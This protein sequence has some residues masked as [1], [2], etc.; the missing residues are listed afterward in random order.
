MDSLVMP[1]MGVQ[2]ISRYLAGLLVSLRF[3]GNAPATDTSFVFDNRGGATAIVSYTVKQKQEWPG[4]TIPALSR[5]AQGEGRW[6]ELKPGDYLA[7]SDG[8]TRTIEVKTGESLR[9]AIVQR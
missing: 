1:N 8:R 5:S 2:R 4:S 6:R 7:S 9:V 3:L